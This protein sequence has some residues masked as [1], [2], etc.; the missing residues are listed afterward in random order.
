M[1]LENFKISG[2][3]ELALAVADLERA[4][5][6]YAGTLGLPVVE[7]WG[8][9]V[10]VMAGNRTRIGLWLVSVAPLAGER[11]GSHV[12]FALH[13][14]EVDLDALIGRL[15]AEGHTVHLE[16]FRDG[17]GRAAYVSDPDGHVVEFWTW[18]V[19]RHLDE[20]STGDRDPRSI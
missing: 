7:R 13:I 17:R 14:S 9:A 11:G 10:W 5:H 18:D 4:E 6:F 1:T 20:L 8:D 2:V 15:E 12:H 19:A 3:S 16:R